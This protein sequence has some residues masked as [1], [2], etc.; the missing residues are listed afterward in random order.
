MPEGL[1]IMEDTITARTL[2][3]QQ[4]YYITQPHIYTLLTKWRSR[5]ERLAQAIP[6]SI[7]KYTPHTEFNGTHFLHDKS[8]VTDGRRNSFEKYSPR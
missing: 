3:E 6:S 4:K 1:G 7:F 2:N 8:S 5:K